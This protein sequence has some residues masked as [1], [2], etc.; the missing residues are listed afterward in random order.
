MLVKTAC[1]GITVLALLVLLFKLLYLFLQTGGLTVQRADLTAG[2]VKQSGTLLELGGDDIKVAYLTGD[3]RFSAGKYLLLP[4]NLLLHLSAFLTHL[5]DDGIGLARH[6]QGGGK[7]KQQ[8]DIS[9]HHK[10]RLSRSSSSDTCFMRRVT[11]VLSGHVLLSVETD[12][13]LACT[14]TLVSDTLTWKLSPNG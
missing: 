8:Y 13:N 9:L 10:S 7:H 12:D 2:L 4:C 5:L 14:F 6:E 3:V 1:L 11:W